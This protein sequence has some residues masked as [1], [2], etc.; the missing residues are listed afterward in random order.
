MKN[1]EMTYEQAIALHKQ[2]QNNKNLK[3]QKLNAQYKT[4]IFG[5]VHARGNKKY[6]PDVVFAHNKTIT[7]F[8]INWAKH[9]TLEAGARLTPEYVR[10]AE[11]AFSRWA[12]CELGWSY[13]KIADKYGDYGSFSL[14]ATFFGYYLLRY[15]N[16]IIWGNIIK[17]KS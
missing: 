14:Q 6:S 10:K 11:N 7:K 16:Q 3:A 4:T 12:T 13:T 1:S 15:A 5:K 17:R 2:K 9:N 8:F